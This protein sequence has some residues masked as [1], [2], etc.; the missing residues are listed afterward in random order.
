MMVDLVSMHIEDQSLEKS[1]NEVK[2]YL[3]HIHI[4]DSNRLAPG[5]GN[6][7]FKKIINIIKNI[8]YDGYISVEIKQVP[9]KDIVLKESIELIKPLLK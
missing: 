1:F 2:P 8:D 9:H 3:K 7:D 6:L 4:C 5:Y